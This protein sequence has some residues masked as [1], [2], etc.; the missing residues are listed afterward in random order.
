MYRIYTGGVPICASM[1]AIYRWVISPEVATRDERADSRPGPYGQGR[2][3]V[4]TTGLHCGACPRR[5]SWCDLIGSS[6][7]RRGESPVTGTA[8]RWQ[9]RRSSATHR[10]RREVACRPRP[11]HGF[12]PYCGGS[13]TRREGSRSVATGMW[14]VAPVGCRP[15]M[16]RSLGRI[17]DQSTVRTPWRTTC[18][19]ASSAD[20]RLL[21]VAAVT[22][23]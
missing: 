2:T 12:G 16:R 9:A 20:R 8:R 15:S 3:V 13:A 21:S 17:P 11:H 23:P 22:G 5:G 1:T 4:P 14:T 7:P 6:E 18:R 19:Q 10:P